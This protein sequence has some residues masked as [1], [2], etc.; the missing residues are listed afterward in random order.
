MFVIS[1]TATSANET[2]E[3]ISFAAHENERNESTEHKVFELAWSE[4]SPL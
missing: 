1:F 3:A 4:C 2:I